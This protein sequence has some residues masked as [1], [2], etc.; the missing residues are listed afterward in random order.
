MREDGTD[1]LDAWL[2]QRERLVRL[3]YRYLGSA[4]EAEDVV[5]DAWLRF[6]DGPQALEPARYLSRIVTNLCLD[7]LKSAR[8]R[9]E[10]YVGPWLPEPIAGEAPGPD[11]AGDA[12]LD[13]S[14]GVMRSLERLSPQERA[15]LFLHDLFDLTFEEIGETLHRSPA[16]CRQMAVRAR[17]ALKSSKQ[18]FKPST[19]DVDRFV[20]RLT[21]TLQ[22]GDLEPLKALLAADVEFISDGGGKV[23]A[24]R[25]VVAGADNVARLLLGLARKRDIEDIDPRPVAINGAPGLLLVIGGYLDQTMSFGL[26][27]DGRISAI[28]VVR[29]P[30]KLTRVQ[31][32]SDVG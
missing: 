4:S 7:R 31:L 6:A 19:E 17:T 28:Y 10:T 27:A 13:I 15:A 21:Q 20:A 8:A 11:E 25:N 14:F 18:R 16:A 24:A 3:A 30:D 2:G 5:Q 22:T 23:S 29:N 32:P 26:D 1:K 12:A 9:R